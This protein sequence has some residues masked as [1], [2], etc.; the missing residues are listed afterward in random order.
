MKTMLRTAL[1]MALLAS[2]GSAAAQDQDKLTSFTVCADPGNMPLSNNKGEGF[3]NKIAE[4]LGQ[5]LGTGVQY[6]WRPSIE[7]GLMRSTLSSGS[8]DL[9][10]DMASDTEG[11]EVTTPLYRSTF[12]FVYR[13]DSGIVVKDFDDPALEHNRIGVFQVSAIRQA[14]AAHGI[15]QNTVIQYL[16]H[17]GDLVPENQ[18]SYQVQ[19]VID[20]KLEIAGVW[21][22]MAGYYK[23][24]KKAPLVIQPV[25]LMDDTVPLEFD[26]AMA[27]PRGRP[28]LKS[29]IEKAMRD[30]KD[31]IH[32]ILVEY[33]VPL[34]KCDDCIIDGTLQSH[35]PYKPVVPVTQTAAIGDHT[36]VEDLKKW[37]KQGA[38][39]NEELGNAVIANDIER[40][41]YLV[42]HGADASTRDGDG[43]TALGNAVRFGY[44][45]IATLLIEHKA[46]TNATDLSGWTPLMYAAWADNAELVTLLLAHGAKHDITK[47]SQGLT[48]LAIAAQ[49]GKSK[50]A[51]VLIDAGADVNHA[52]GQGSYTPLMLAATSGSSDIAQKLVQKGAD[53]NARNPGGVTALMIAAA[54]NR[55]EIATLLIQSGADPNLK[56]EDGR[57]A[58]SIA[59]SNNSDAVVKLLKQAA[60]KPGGKST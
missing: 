53:V 44:V 28:E 27:V 54:G 25:N 41:R 32:A 14:L 20:K 55:T 40:V 15:M 24:I 31:K 10:M 21:G 16:S 34:V 13:E 35:G 22:P 23:S 45:P 49:N 43:Y 58:L 26:M 48:P 56:S 3:Q 47:E 30:S 19:Q 59:E 46:D 9:W 1:S 12:V 39:P 52:V 7:R 18:P 5:A 2:A 17:N 8:C 42:D 50:A 4:V 33:G 11:A 37:L 38:N 57:T 36:T 29:A 51:M 6:Y 60:Q